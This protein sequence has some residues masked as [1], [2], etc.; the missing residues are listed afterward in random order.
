MK[1]KFFGRGA[2]TCVGLVFLLSGCGSI[3][4]ILPFGSEKPQARSRIL[5]DATEYQCK[6]GT[7]F[8]VRYL[9]NGAA[10]WVILPDR[11]FRLD[12]R[13]DSSA[14]RYGNGAAV[15]DIVGNE[16]T[17]ADGATLSYKDCKTPGSTA[18][19]ALQK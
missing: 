8:H 5:A 4:G 14:G 16:A 10:A 13:G 11:E 2:A 18:D 3:G 17:L 12:K 6:G 1:M 19:S 7:R 15:L 9:D